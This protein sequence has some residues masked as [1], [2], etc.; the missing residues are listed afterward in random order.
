MCENRGYSDPTLLEDRVLQNLLQREEK[1]APSRTYFD[2]VQKDLSPN[3]RK[4]VA[5][6][7]L[8][9]STDTDSRSTCRT[10]PFSFS[11]PAGESTD[12]DSIIS[13]TRRWLVTPF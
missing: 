7:M 3:M 9:A 13:R 11:M 1:Y 12:R 6:W 10:S 2:S 8:E 4:I 5:E